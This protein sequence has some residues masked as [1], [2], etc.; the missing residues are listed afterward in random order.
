MRRTSIAPALLALL[1]TL[2]TACAPQRNL[3]QVQGGLVEA[4]AKKQQELAVREYMAK[5]DRMDR[6]AWAIRSKN[7]DLCGEHTAYRLG[8]NLAEAEDYPKDQREII[9]NALGIQ[10]R[11][12]VYIIT[13][14]GPAEAA[15]VQRGDVLLSV[16]GQEVKNKKHALEHL[17]KALASGSSIPMAVERAGLRHELSVPPAKVCA[18]DVFLKTDNMINAFADGSKI[19]VMT[20][21]MKFVQTDDELAAILGHEMAHNTEGHIKAKTGNALLGML[22]FDL[23]IAILTGVNPNTGG[24]IGQ[25]LYSQEFEHEADYVGLYFTARAGYDIENVADLWRRM[26]VENPGAITMGSTHPSTSARYVALEAARDE[27][28]GKAKEGKELKPEMKGK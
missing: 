14:G 27:I 6:V 13:R 18:Y 26:A 22:L 25:Q 9:Q 21:M 23:P 10:A 5:L 19:T 3:P 17:D 7:V 28:K 12:T 1:L 8:L 4:E 24:Q 16:A 11:P 15:G 20:G 2:L